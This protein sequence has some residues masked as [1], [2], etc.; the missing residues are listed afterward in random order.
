MQ[1]VLTNFNTKDKSSATVGCISCE[2]DAPI[3]SLFVFLTQLRAMRALITNPEQYASKLVNDE[4]PAI[5][6]KNDKTIAALQ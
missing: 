3:R 4:P 1:Q 2:L 5:Q 6:F